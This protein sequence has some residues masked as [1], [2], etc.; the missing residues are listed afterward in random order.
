[1]LAI[2]VVVAI[3]SINNGVSFAAVL[4]PLIEV[5]VMIALVN[6]ALLAQSRR[7]LVTEI[8]KNLVRYNSC[9]KYQ[10]IHLIDSLVNLILHQ[11]TAMIT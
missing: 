1:M 9:I 4:G 2:A 7:L 5:P 6:V 10:L 8:P 11:F 3:F